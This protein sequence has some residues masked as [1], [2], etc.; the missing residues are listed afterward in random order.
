MADSVTIEIN[1]DDDLTAVLSQISDSFDQLE[2][3]TDNAT[4]KSQQ[5]TGAN[6]DLT[7]SAQG[8]S[9]QMMAAGAAMAG[10]AA[11]AAATGLAIR[12]LWNRANQ[13]IEAFR[14]QDEV[15]RALERSLRRTG[16]AGEPLREE[17][18]LIGESID[19]VASQTMLGDE[20]L[21]RMAST[22]IDMSGQA[23]ATQQDLMLIAD[24]SK[25]MGTSGESAAQ[26]YSNALAGQLQPQL[27]RTTQLTRE[28][29]EAINDEDDATRRAELAQEALAAAYG[30]T[31]SDVND[32]FLASKNLEDAKGDLQQAVGQVLAESGAF[33]P[34][35][36]MI[37][38]R[39]RF[40]EDTIDDNREAIQLWIIDAVI[41]T[42]EA[43]QGL[44][45]RMMKLAPV[46]SLVVEYVQQ[47]GRNFRIW[48]NFM[49]IVGRSIAIFGRTVQLGFINVLGVALNAL[50][51]LNE[52]FGRD[53]P[54]GVQQASDTINDMG[55]TI[56]ES[57]EE[58]LEKA[59]ENVNKIRDN[60]RESAGAMDSIIERS[61][62]ISKGLQ[63][64]GNFADDLRDRLEQNREMIGQVADEADRV[65]E[66]RA[67]PVVEE[68]T[69]AAEESIM[70]DREALEQ[71][72]RD[73]IAAIRISALQEEDE[74]LR[75]VMENHA[76]RMEIEARELS[77]TEMRLALLENEIQLNQ[78]LGQIDE[79]E[80][81][82]KLERIEEEERARQQARQ[83][84]IQAQEQILQNNQMLLGQLDQQVSGLGTLTASIRTLSEA[85]FDNAAAYQAME[86]AFSGMAQIGG[87]LAGIV[88]DDRQEAAKVEAAFNAAAAVGAFA[89]WASTGFTA[90]NLGVAFAQHGIAAAQFAAVAGGV[91]SA[92]QPA[93][94]GGSGGSRG[95]RQVNQMS[96]MQEQEQRPIIINNNFS[97]TFI[98][99][100]NVIARRVDGLVEQSAKNRFLAGRG[101]EGRG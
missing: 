99:D 26:L 46:F 42:V 57:V 37:E 81:D 22:F 88:T 101:R 73:T 93:S 34:V 39:F 60:F 80:H 4:N 74:R 75:V 27:A 91:G 43:I 33:S 52:F 65:G 44:I 14:E 56:K 2:Q 35:L 72:H 68:E 25:G 48:V 89:A 10:V 53:I 62:K 7:S 8:I 97:G 100:S 20:E 36:E 3:D 21:S 49:Q 32:L 83:A 87:S 61:A 12:E 1:V 15:N 19:Y 86:S 5:L 90:G 31:A 85:G 92:S 84:E 94:R 66:A 51:S 98:E 18:D 38:E 54:D 79:E 58:Q 29:I 9:P 41:S 55:D 63:G 6:R 76:R 11:A 47:V 82:R 16:A 64:A 30:G 45:G 70:V 23:T 28:Q 78:R 24:I 17:L 69:L 71:Q 59:G 50:I 96:Q 13:A 40:L 95:V 67:Q 77:D